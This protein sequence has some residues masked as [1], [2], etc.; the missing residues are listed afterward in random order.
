MDPLYFHIVAVVLVIVGLAGTVLPL[1][2]GVPLVFGGLLVAA[3][4]DGFQ[5]VGA[6]TLVVLGVLT[7]LAVAADLLASA[8]GAKRMGASPRAVAGATVGAVIGIFFGLPG[9]VLGPFVGAVAGELSANRQLLHAGRAG[10]GTW[11][12]LLLGSIAKLTLAFLMV[13]V[14]ATAW[15]LA[16]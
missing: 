14:F 8:L 9:L 12:G 13:G 15:L 10:L 5:R 1:L 11:I 2:P 6:I 16:G 7:A 4:A 3:W